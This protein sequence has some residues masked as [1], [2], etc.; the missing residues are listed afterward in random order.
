MKKKSENLFACWFILLFTLAVQ[1]WAADAQ[2]E[3]EKTQ[4]F[5]ASTDTFR[6]STD[7]YLPKADGPFSCILIRT[8][9]RKEG[10]KGDIERFI[11]QG[12]A[13]VSQDT[14]GTGQ[15]NGRFYAFSHEREDGLVTVDWIRKQSWSNGRI[16]G[17]GGSYVGYTQLVIADKLD[18]MTPLVT[19]ADMYDALYPAGIFSLALCN[20]WGLMMNNPKLKPEKLLSSYSLLPLSIADDSTG[21]ANAFFDDWLNHPRLDGYWQSMGFRQTSDKPILSIA[22]WYDIFLDPQIKDFLAL[23]PVRHRDS[24]LLIGPFAHG[25]ITIPTDFGDAAKMDRYMDLARSFLLQ[26]LKTPESP[27]T[28]SDSLM[29]KPFAFF[30]V[31]GNRWILSDHWPPEQVQALHLYLSGQGKIAQ[32]KPSA[33]E[34]LTY[35][36]DPNKPYPS[37]GGSFLGIGVGPA[38]QNSNL[39]RTDQ[40]VFET[41]TLTAPLTLLGPQQAHLWVT[42]D[43]SCTDFFACLQDVQ[44]DSQ[45]VNIQEGGITLRAAKG[46]K[47]QEVTISIWPAGYQLNRGHKLRLVICSSLFPRYNRNL[48][49][50]EPIFNAQNSKIA[51]QKIFIGKRHPSHLELSVLP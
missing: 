20:N 3:Y 4:L 51:Q 23:G 16:A 2:P 15:S 1:L 11:K 25:K 41:D 32:R 39:S 24:H 13:V 18:A 28:F 12:F 44:P 33:N 14:R 43:A 21:A 22:G 8:P 9:Y 30:I 19:T 38:W 40:V 49:S 48:N 47:A 36:Y 46:E 27:A 7:V 6:L 42:S 34:Q 17:W 50:C 5:I 31:H 29:S 26:A 10:F 37:L 35:R 45:I